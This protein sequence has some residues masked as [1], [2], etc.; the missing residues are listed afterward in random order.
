VRQLSALEMSIAIAIIR[1]QFSL[2]HR[3]VRG[4]VVSSDLNRARHL[5]TFGARKV[6]INATPVLLNLNEAF[7]SL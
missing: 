4:L 6:C 3:K 5:I 7:R 1:K 2:L